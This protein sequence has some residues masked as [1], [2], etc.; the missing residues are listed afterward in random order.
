[1]R[2]LVYYIATSVDGFIADQEGDTAAFP[3]HPDTLTA[4][5][6]RYPETCPAHVRDALGVTASPR[7]FDTVIMGAHT[8][9][10]AVAAGL[11]DGAYPHLRQI[12][13][14]HQAI[15]TQAVDTMSGDVAAQVRHLKHEAGQDIWLCGGSDLATQ[16]AD[17]IDEIQ[18]K[19][20]PV[21]FG[22]GIPLFA[23]GAGP[24]SLDCTDVTTLPSGVV[25]VTYRAGGDTPGD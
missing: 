22:T 10:P 4:L 16:L 11:P 12:V 17:E 3:V 25:L 18:V 5:F 13:V 9:A 19:I 20:N 21:V 8:Y 7:R 23:T 6:D 15:D 24:R 14:T 1:M 2:S